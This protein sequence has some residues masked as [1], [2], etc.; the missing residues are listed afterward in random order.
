V[1]LAKHSGFSL[2][3]MPSFVFNFQLANKLHSI[4][5]IVS[6]AAA[7]VVRTAIFSAKLQQFDF[8]VMIQLC[9]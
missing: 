2:V 9:D 5:Y 7:S 8:E 6:E 4:V 3:I 1:L